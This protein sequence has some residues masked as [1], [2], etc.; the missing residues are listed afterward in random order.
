MQYRMHPSISSFPNSNFYSNKIIDAPNVKIRSYEKCYLPG[1][2]FGPYSFINV[3]GGREEVDDVGRSQRNMA[4]AAV[5]LKLIHCLYKAWNGLKQNLSIGVISPYAAQVVA[6][7]DKLSSKYEKVD[8][9]S[10]KVQSI[11]GFQGGE[12]DIVII[13]TVRS[14]SSGGIGFVSDPRR[15]NV[16]LTRARHCL[17]ILGNERTLFRSRSIWEMLIRDA[18]HRQCF[19]NADENKELAK[20][21]LDVKKEFDQLDDLLNGN[22]VLFKCA[23]WKVLFSE[24]FRRSFGKLRAKWTRTFCFEP[25]LEKFPKFGQPQFDIVR[26]KSLLSTIEAGNDSNFGACSDSKWLCGKLQRTV[27]GL[28]KHTVLTDEVVSERKQ[29]F[30]WQLKEFG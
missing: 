27:R 11:D 24:Y 1:P 15:V 22:S 13:S 20:A 8:G 28:E 30:Q 21:I 5:V 19:F 26:Y 6:I 7:Q 10:V 18:K 25:R 9:F 29:Q 17:W 2:M 12:E 4:E 14:N 3:N 23:R 16:S